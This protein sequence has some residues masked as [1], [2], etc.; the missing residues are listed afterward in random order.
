[1]GKSKRDAHWQENEQLADKAEKVKAKPLKDGKAKVWKKACAYYLSV[2]HF[3]YDCQKRG[4]T[5]PAQFV[6]H[7]DQPSNQVEFWNIDNWQALCE[8]CHQRITQGMTLVVHEPIPK[9][10]KLYT[11]K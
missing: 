5:S 2:N 3:C 4:Y 1:M 6:A 11:V 7:I 9:D 10:I 8:P